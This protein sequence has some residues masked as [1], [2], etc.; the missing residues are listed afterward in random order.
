[1]MYSRISI[2]N[3]RG[4]ES[5][6]A[7]RLRRI[8]LILGRNSS[9]KTTFLESLFLLGGRLDPR[10]MTTLGQ[11]R[12][13]RL[14][15]THPDPIWRAMFRELD[16]NLP[17]E[18]VGRWAEEPEAR[19]LTI[20]ALATSDQIE[21]IEQWQGAE[22]DTSAALQYEVISLLQLTYKDGE[23]GEYN[24]L[25]LLDPSSG[26]FGS[27]S[28]RRHDVVPTSLLPARSFASP[29]RVAQQ[30]S[31]VLKRKQDK[32]VIDALRIIEPRVQRI[33]VVSEASGPSIYLDIGLGALVP[34][35]VCGEGMVRLFSIILE[36]L[37]SRN[38]VLL[39]DEIDNGLH[40]TIMPKL[41]DLL[42]TMVEKHQVQVFGTTHSDD[43][44][45]S[46]L[47]VFAGK[48]GILGLFRIDKRGDRHVMV[49]YSD[50]AMQGVREVPF[51]VRG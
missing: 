25:A 47:D 4:I 43:I 23:G 40:Y 8:N 10:L 19:E 50:E 39:I 9:G 37:A 46:A 32:D 31:S 51:E 41:W 33:E 3:F 14:G 36:L 38:G 24:E 1:M 21:A 13:Q 42:N 48:E 49:A 29:I 5:L 15:G 6:E 17:I 35:A 30:F 27:S 2:K 28:A 18:I 16:T 22:G 26:R 44:I 34:L 12:G 11:M 7:T 20:V 45:R